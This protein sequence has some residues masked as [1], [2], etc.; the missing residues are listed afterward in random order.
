MNVTLYVNQSETNVLD[1]RLI[2]L[3]TMTGDLIDESSVINPVIRIRGIDAHIATMNYAYIPEMGRFYFITDVVCVCSN[4]FDVSMH[5]DVLHTY[6]DE[7]RKNNA[8]IARN[9]NA[10]DLKL[11]DGL[12]RTQQNPRIAQFPFPRGFDTWDY[13][14]A[15]SGN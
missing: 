15:I 6:R 8:I 10:Y 14:L 1:K 12:F 11:N 3:V 4:V 9:E 13:V 7:I 2:E 5:V